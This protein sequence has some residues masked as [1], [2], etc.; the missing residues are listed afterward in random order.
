VQYLLQDS[1]QEGGIF[2][3]V[4][5]NASILD[6][7]EAIREIQPDIATHYTEQDIRTH[8][9]F[10]V[11]GDKLKQL[12]WSPR[13]SLEAGFAEMIGRFTNLTKMPTLSSERD[14]E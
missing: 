9:S 5:I 13:V 7:V 12:G 4:G 1:D 6:L 11:S 2:N 3:V 14:E 10:D 8:F